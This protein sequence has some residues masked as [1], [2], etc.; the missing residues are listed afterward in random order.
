[1]PPKQPDRV[2]DARPD[3]LDFRDLMFTPTLVEVPTTIPLETYRK[4]KVPILDQGTEGACTGFGL[5]TV[6][7]YLL[8][9][10]RVVPTK[11]RVSPRMLYDLARRYDEWP[12][13]NYSGSSA[14]GA[15][16]GWH[17]HGVCRDRMWPK[18]RDKEARRADDDARTTDALRAPARRV[19]PREPQGHRR[20]ARRHRRGRHPVRH[21]RGAPGLARRRHDGLIA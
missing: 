1:M 16:K 3:T 15:M 7:N 2:L 8:R 19:L 14:R 6:A 12:G 20:D 10:R 4:F 17:K 13:E 18:A 5:A 9:R 11:D 21:R